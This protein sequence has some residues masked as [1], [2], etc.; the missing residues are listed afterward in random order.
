MG[1]IGGNQCRSGIVPINLLPN[2]SFEQNA[3]PI[4][5]TLKRPPPG[6]WR[7]KAARKAASGPV[8]GGYGV[9]PQWAESC[10]NRPFTSIL[11]SSTQL[12]G[13]RGAFGAAK[14]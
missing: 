13:G 9:I 12:L 5:F 14:A 3:L 11:T 7:R 4:S 6:S 10:S 8:L 1:E 2:V